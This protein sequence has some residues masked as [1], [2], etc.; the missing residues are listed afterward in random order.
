MNVN[1]IEGKKFSKS[2]IGQGNFDCLKEGSLM[3]SN[4]K[5]KFPEKK[6]PKNNECFDCSK[7]SNRNYTKKKKVK[8][9]KKK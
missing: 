3:Y 4:P 9:S 6:P 2:S 8:K 7:S 5:V 1:I